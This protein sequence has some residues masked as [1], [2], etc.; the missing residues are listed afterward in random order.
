MT[1]EQLAEV[2]KNI[3]QMLAALDAAGLLVTLPTGEKALALPHVRELLL[4]TAQQALTQMEA[5][6]T[7]TFDQMDQDLNALLD[8]TKKRP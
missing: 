7:T 6:I 3:D 5:V 2:N 1:E 8:S 4:L